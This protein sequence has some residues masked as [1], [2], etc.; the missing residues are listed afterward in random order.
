MNIIFLSFFKK[1]L[2]LFTGRWLTTFQAKWHPSMDIFCSGSMN[3][4]RCTEIYDAHGKLL[5][6]ITGE[7]LSSVMSRT[8]FHPSINH[9][10]MVGGN[11]S[12]RVV[13][14]Q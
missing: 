1:N 2:P 5:R 6:A 12:G 9:L 8:C 7:S 10:V 14:I 11:S 3:K 4:P 13:V